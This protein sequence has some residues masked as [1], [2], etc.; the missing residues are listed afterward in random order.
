MELPD[1]D[2]FSLNTFFKSLRKKALK[3]CLFFKNE[4]INTMFSDE[5]SRTAS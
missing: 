4:A 5:T 2:P 3:V 1:K